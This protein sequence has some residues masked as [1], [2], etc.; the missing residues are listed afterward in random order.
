MC[1]DGCTICNFPRAIRCKLLLLFGGTI[2]Q[3]L[4]HTPTH[5]LTLTHLL[6][7]ARLALSR[8][9]TVAERE[10]TLSSYLSIIGAKVPL[11]GNATAIIAVRQ[12]THSSAEFINVQDAMAGGE[13]LKFPSPWR[14]PALIESATTDWGGKWRTVLVVCVVFANIVG[15]KYTVPLV[16]VCPYVVDHKCHQLI[17]MARFDIIVLIPSLPG[18]CTEWVWETIYFFL[19]N[20]CSYP[21]CVNKSRY[22][23]IDNVLQAIL[24][25]QI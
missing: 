9:C 3:S 16:L 18:N 14:L 1:T 5:S 17:S 21:T 11:L 24:W 10:R 13:W 25:F 7:S 15:E 12:P 20:I 6:T 8:I 4:I 19:N 2:M 22:Y 23:Y